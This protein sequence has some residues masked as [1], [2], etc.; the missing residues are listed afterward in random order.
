MKFQYGIN[1]FRIFIMCFFIKSVNIKIR[2]SG[3]FLIEPGYM[4][5][6]CLFE[7]NI[8]KLYYRISK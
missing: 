8:F 2:V 7:F 5:V 4:H 1:F 3:I 6:L